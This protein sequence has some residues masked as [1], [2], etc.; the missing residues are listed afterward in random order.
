MKT[1]KDEHFSRF[2]KE[3]LF[4][5]ICLVGGTAAMEAHFSATSFILYVA[6]VIAFVVAIFTL[7]AYCGDNDHSK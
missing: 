2:L 1:R 7:V 3:L 5:F 4:S 6:A